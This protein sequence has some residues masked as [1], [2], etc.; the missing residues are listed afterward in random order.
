M[1]MDTTPEA[2]EY[3][4]CKCADVCVRVI[5]IYTDQSECLQVHVNPNKYTGFY[6][7]P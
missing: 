1:Q 6:E 7:N 3:H 4:I 2:I 5:E